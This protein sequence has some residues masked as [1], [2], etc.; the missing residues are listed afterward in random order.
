V[1]PGPSGGAGNEKADEWTRLAAE[2][3]DAHGVEWLGYADDYGR[4]L[5]PPSRSL[6]TVKRETSEKKWAEARRCAEGRITA[7]KY[8][9]PGKHRPSR[10]VDRCPKRLAGRFP[11]LKTGHCHTGQYRK[12]SK[13]CATA[14][15]GW[16]PWTVRTR[17]HLPKN[18]RQWKP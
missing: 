15:C 3:P 8:K 13:S 12:W 16:C 17:E 14:K 5:M 4:R 9:M 7:R 1:V 2:E 6:T 18:C 11:Q 10:E